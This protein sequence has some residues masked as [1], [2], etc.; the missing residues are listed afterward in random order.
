MSNVTV[1][2]TLLKGSVRQRA[3]LLSNHYI[4]LS[5]G[6]KGY[7]SES[8][9]NT[10][11]NSFK[12]PEEIR[13]Y[14]QYKKMSY[15]VQLF[16]TNISQFRLT[17]AELLERLEKYILLRRSNADME[18][19]VNNLLDLM[20]DKKTRVKGVKIAKE[21]SSVS[22]FRSIT[23]DKENYVK[24][25][26]DKNSLDDVIDNIRNNVKYEQKRLKS[27]LAMIKD[28]LSETGFKV[29]AFSDY[30]KE[31]ENWAKSTKDKELTSLSFNKVTDKLK[32]NGFKYILEK[33]LLEL[34]YE[35]VEIDKELYSKFRREYFG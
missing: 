5:S 3:L 17:Y 22:L 29:K 35:D 20:P 10:L 23:T 25:I 13:V 12:K 33:D 24:I 27:A 7:L 30:I 15:N 2:K 34:S 1:D 31:V 18:D 9:K 4:D 6:G 11:E 8:E 14:N 16:I 21:F 28:Y 32:S 19:L 26:H